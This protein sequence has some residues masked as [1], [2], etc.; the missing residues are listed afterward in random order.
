MLSDLPSWVLL[1]VAIMLAAPAVLL[2]RRLVPMLAENRAVGAAAAR[3]V[4]RMACGIALCVLAVGFFALVSSIA[5]GQLAAL[6]PAAAVLVTSAAA[7]AVGG[8]VGLQC[9][10]APRLAVLASRTGAVVVG[11]TFVPVLLI[12]ASGAS[13]ARDLWLTVDVGIVAGV[14]AVIVLGVAQLR[15]LHAR[16]VLLRTWLA[17]GGAMILGLSLLVAFD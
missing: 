2:G 14:V 16:S 12:A 6:S 4:A 15:H 7:G 1:A 10:R 17:L 13:D 8:I 5:R 9:D 11:A 3:P